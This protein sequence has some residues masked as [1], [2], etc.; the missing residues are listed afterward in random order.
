MYVNYIKEAQSSN[1]VKPVIG[2]LGLLAQCCLKYAVEFEQII[3]TASEKPSVSIFP[4][5]VE[6]DSPNS[7]KSKSPIT[8]SNTTPTNDKAKQ[9]KKSEK[10]KINEEIK[11]KKLKLE[12]LNRKLEKK[13]ELIKQTK[14]KKRKNSYPNQ[15]HD[16]HYQHEK[17][18]SI[19]PIKF[20]PYS[21]EF[22]QPKQSEIEKQTTLESYIQT[23]S[24]I[25]NLIK[26]SNS[27][28]SNNN[29]SLINNFYSTPFVEH[30][31]ISNDLKAKRFSPYDVSIK[32]THK[33]TGQ[34]QQLVNE[35]YA[36]Q[37]FK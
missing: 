7:R 35:C 3:K 15:N 29:P 37:I 19:A 11:R 18:T 2:H 22:V 27:N 10:M 5:S 8:F 20:K 13:L 1:Q 21:E 33:R 31:T 12:K 17:E 30:S 36:P 24:F 26:I 34:F 4:V 28:N 32:T 14:L 9:E 6:V 23:K 16:K 25:E